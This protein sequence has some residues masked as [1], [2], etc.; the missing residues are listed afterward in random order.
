MGN[1][2]TAD[3][4]FETLEKRVATLERQITA[5]QLVLRELT[6]YTDAVAAD[7]DDMLDEQDSGPDSGPGNDSA[8]EF[9]G[10]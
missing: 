1:A 7:V 9:W 2:R 6:G 3:E 5:L 8:G 10:N 4:K